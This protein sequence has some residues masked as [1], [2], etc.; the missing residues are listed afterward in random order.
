MV[1]RAAHLETL[2]ARAATARAGR[3]QLVVLD[4]P[5]GAGKT[6]LLRAAL[7]GGGPFD[8]MTVLYG[9]CR[10][11]DSAHGYS[12]V[13]ALFGPL[14]PTARRGRAATLLDGAA[15]HALPALAPDLSDTAHGNGFAVMNG[16]YWLSANLMADRPLVLALDD[17]HWCDERSL[18]WLDFLLRRA[19]DMPLLVVLALR[20]ESGPAAGPALTDLVAHHQHLPLRLTALSAP[21]VG[22]LVRSA[23][24]GTEP[25]ASFV[26]ALTSVTGG[27]PLELQWLLHRLHSAGVRADD[28]GAER[29]TEIGGRVIAP[30]VQEVLDGQPGRVREVARALAVLGPE[31]PEHLAALAGVSLV[32]AEEALEILRR[33]ALLQPDRLE[34]LHDV[35]RT[36]ILS[37]LGPAALARLRTRA[38]QLLSDVGRSPEQI[39]G[40]LLLLPEAD[41]PW[42]TSVLSAAAAQAEQRGAPEAAARYLELVLRAAPDDPQARMRL[43]ECLAETDPARSVTLLREALDLADDVRT[44]ATVAVR[45]GLACL[46]VQRSPEGARVLTEALDALDTALGPVPEPADQE[47]RTFVESALLIVGADEKS[48]MPLVR[49]RAARLTPPPGHTPAQRQQLAMLTV[50]T[51]MDGRSA[52]QAV[53]Q[54]RR[55][56]HSPGVPLG[57]WSLLPASLVLSLADET[58]E[59]LAALETVLVDSRRSAA[60]WTYVLALGTRAFVHL[61]NGVITHAMADAQ[62]AME[63]LGDQEWGEGAAMPQTAYA[64]ALTERG[65]PARA[66][67]VLD[68]IKR[69]RL[70]RFVWE[71]HWYLMARARARRARGD[72]QGALDLL[73]T[74]G[75][76]LAECGLANPVLAPWWLDAACLLADAGR[77]AEA[78][79][80]AGHGAALAERWGTRRALGY[81]ALARGAATPG[82]DGTA[83]LREAAGRLAASPAH[84]DHARALVHLGRALLAEGERREAREHLRDAVAL[85][86]RC[87]SLALAR[88]A[89]EI[90][91]GAGG[92]MR[93]ITVS[94]LDMLT[95][96]ERTVATLVA[97]GASNREAAESLFV[98]VRTVELHLTS[99]YRK[100]GV[101]RRADLAAVLDTDVLPAQAPH[102]AYA[103]PTAPWRG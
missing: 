17:V 80:T 46:S 10:A 42:M 24:P 82:P 39:A 61:D 41:E 56:L 92:R 35:V 48:T 13:R 85:A 33:A 89:R 67:E 30:A 91:V 14:N 9:A 72:A 22:E 11:V 4:G 19:D 43:A 20:T 55:A 77:H 96:T 69:P 63:L 32:Q 1:G 27:N 75:D 81:A 45:F 52:S 97:S 49:A 90:L 98:T 6:S 60:V 99:V 50:L 84:A 78:R 18:R 71:Y 68:T 34:L 16:L 2:A 101:T 54:A 15:R 28:A 86:R 57:A 44:R 62:T 40:Q 38:A 58:G 87:G 53:R 66:E 47:L 100:L 21:E 95:G 7:D 74:C 26:A 25:S 93:E 31:H 23:L 76:S 103:R 12:G 3:P 8:G 29:V 36:A 59:A 51:A 70:D 5:A 65:E 79:A 88:Q 73:R 37:T 64:V 94:P 83:L 102:D